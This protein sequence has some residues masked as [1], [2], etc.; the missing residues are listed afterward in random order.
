MFELQEDK[1]YVIHRIEIISRSGSNK[2]HTAISPYLA[3]A[4]IFQYGKL[5][6]A[7]EAINRLGMFAEI[8]RKDC[9]VELDGHA[10]G[11]AGL[12]NLIFTV[13]SKKQLPLGR[14]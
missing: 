9:R 5:D 2:V 13:T 3:E 11:H 4:G 12:A 8:S 7:I 1:Q 6:A 14:D 10:E